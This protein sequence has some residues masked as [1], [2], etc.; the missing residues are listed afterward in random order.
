MQRCLHGRPGR[1][2]VID[3]D[4]RAPFDRNACA[5]GQIELAPTFNLI[6]LPR[7]CRCKIVFGD[8]QFPDQ[9]LVEHRLCA[10]AVDHGAERELGLERGADLAHEHEI[11]W[12]PERLSNLEPDRHAA[13]RQGQHDR[14]RPRQMHQPLGELAPGIAAIGEQNLTPEHGQQ[15]PVQRG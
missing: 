12:C 14:A 11:E 9:I 7:T 15:P 10:A 8:L 6:Q 13:A 2:A 1:D 3:H 5:T 4:R